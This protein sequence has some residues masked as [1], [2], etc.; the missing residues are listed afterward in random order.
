VLLLLLL[1]LLVPHWQQTCEIENVSQRRYA[2]VQ[3]L[4]AN[5]A[6]EARP[7]DAVQHAVLACLL[8]TT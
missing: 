4:P 1:L 2:S 7:M 6:A 8:A 5:T 3:V